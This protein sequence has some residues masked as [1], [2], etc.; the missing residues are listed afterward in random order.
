MMQYVAVLG[1]EEEFI[2][3]D[4]FDRI[5]GCAKTAAE[6]L[7]R[8]L[9]LK[10]PRRD[11]KSVSVQVFRLVIE[12]GALKRYPAGA[13]D[14]MPS[15]EEM[16]S[17]EYDVEMHSILERIPQEFWPFVQEH[18]WN[19]GHASG[20]EQVMYIAKELVDN[21]APC[22][23]NYCQKLASNDIKLDRSSR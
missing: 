2:E 15:L 21:L 18:S 12:R 23:H 17:D 14:I 20:H 16:T 13:Y 11:P 10:T 1:E 7:V 8:R 6:T 5:K 3:C 22:I 9:K 4:P 19:E